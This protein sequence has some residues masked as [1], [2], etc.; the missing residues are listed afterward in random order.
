MHLIC[1]D[2]SVISI[3]MFF[4]A[5][6]TE[7]VI[8]P[9][10]AVFS[11]KQSYDS[12]WQIANCATGEGELRFYK[13]NEIT[14]ANVPLVMRNRLWYLDQDIASTVYR[15]TIATASDTFVNRMTG[16]TLHNL[17]HH[18][19]CHAGQYVTDHIDKVTDGVPSLRKRN[20]FF[21][22]TDCSRGK[23]TSKK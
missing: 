2:G 1:A 7:T 21:S 5:D 13:S 20:P 23:M 19:L 15:S 11:N 16:S 17:W 8:F 6:A 18:R 12:W 22:C 3:T 14:I 4:S 9:I 10:D